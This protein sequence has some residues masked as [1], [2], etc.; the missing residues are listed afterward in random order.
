MASLQRPFQSEACDPLGDV[1]WGIFIKA[2]GLHRQEA[3]RTEGERLL[4]L[5]LSYAELGDYVTAA[6]HFLLS[7]GRDCTLYV[8]V[9]ALQ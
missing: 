7:H 1:L 4:K 5:L 3:T 2:E 6:A 9:V 8:F